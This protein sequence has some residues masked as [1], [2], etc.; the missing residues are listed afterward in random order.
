M[1]G[2]I[3]KQKPC[4]ANR[5]T[6][7]AVFFIACAFWT[8]AASAA[9][10]ILRIDNP[11]TNA[12]VI[13]TLYNSADTFVNLRDPV[14]T[15]TLQNN[16]ISPVQI[17]GL[18]EGEY[19]LVVYLDENNNGRLDKNFI[20]IPREPLGFSNRYWPQ[21]PP[22]F[23]SAAFHLNQEETKAFDI[24]LQSVFGKLGL[25]GVGVG[26]IAQTSVYRD[27]EHVTIQPIPAV[28][29]IGDRVQILGPSAQCG[30]LKGPNFGLALTAS[31]RLGAYSED[32]SP[33]LNGLGD[34]DDTL[35]AG[36]AL[37]ADLPAGLEVSGGYEHDLL[38]RNSGGNGRLGIDKAF[39]RR[40]LTASPQL[41][42]N[43]LTA[44]LADYEFGV[45]AARATEER[46]AYKPDDVIS[47]EA[48]LNIFI[49]LPGAWRIILNGSV[50]FLPSEITE[51][52][53]VDQSQIFSG[54]LAINRIF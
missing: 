32:D 18:A 26:V 13:A 31:Y 20:G 35:M 53:I 27:S 11:P 34:R 8:S 44:D 39:Q 54:F 22:T 42:L 3:R 19:A 46:P 40:Q 7:L 5:T 37:Q 21:G 45:P 6:D 36:M 51:S 4:K 2:R 48:G 29:Y 33:Y 24:E 28:S 1:N 38:S 16:A 23:A 43:W 10:L 50:A 9:E 30:I 25:L 14:K 15:L 52:P 47:I 41:A 12:S 17:L 49:E